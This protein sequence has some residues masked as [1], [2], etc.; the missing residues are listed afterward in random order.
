[1]TVIFRTRF[2]IYN[3]FGFSAYRTLEYS[4]GHLICRIRI[5]QSL[6]M[7]ECEA[8]KKENIF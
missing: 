7:L 1:M 4:D 6:C 3:D 2:G 8:G 5:E